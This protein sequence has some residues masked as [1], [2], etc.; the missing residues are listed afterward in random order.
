MFV[1]PVFA[2][3]LSAFFSR[4]CFFADDLPNEASFA[5]RAPVK[6]VPAPILVNYPSTPAVERLMREHCALVR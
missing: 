5:I 2:Y 6:S 3:R 1:P 4:D